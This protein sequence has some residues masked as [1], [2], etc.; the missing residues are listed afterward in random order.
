MAEDRIK[1][2]ATLLKRWD[3]W[4]DGIGHLVDSPRINGMYFA[5]GLLG[6]RRELRPAPFL[7]TVT[8]L[9]S[10][11]RWPASS[12]KKLTICAVA[13]NPSSGGTVTYDAVSTGGATSTSLTISHTCT[14]ANRYLTVGVST[15]GAAAPTGVT[16]DGSAMTKLVEDTTTAGAICSIWGIKNPSTGANN[17]I[18]SMG[19]SVDIRGGGISFTSVD[20]TT[21]TNDTDSISGTTG[22]FPDFWASS[23]ACLDNGRVVGVSATSDTAG[24]SK[25]VDE[26]ARWDANQG[27][28]RG[29]GTDRAKFTGYHPTYVVEEEETTN[30]R[31]YLYMYR[32][33]VDGSTTSLLPKLTKINIFDANFSF[34]QILGEFEFNTLSQPGQP[35]RYQGNWF[36][37]ASGSTISRKLTVGS[38]KT[39]ADTLTG[40]T[41]VANPTEDHLANLSH[42]L[43]GHRAT[44][45][46][47]ILKVDGTPTTEGDWGSYFSVGDKNERAAGLIG[48]QNLSFVMN[49]E[50]LFSFN[51][52]G[53]SGL[54]FE[55]FRTW[56]NVFENIPM[57]AWK[58]GILLPHPSGL[59][60]YTPGEQPIH[61][62]L[63]SKVGLRS[64][65]PSGPTEIHGGRYHGTKVVGEFI[66]AVYQPN[67]SS[68]TAYLTCAYSPSG[69]PTDLIWQILGSI[70]LQD[71]NYVMGVGV[72]LQSRPV[73][74]NYV[75]PVAWAGNGDDLNYVV[76]DSSAGPF[77][78]RADTHKVNTSANAYM[79]EIIFPE[80]VDLTEIVIYTQ[81]MISGD[82]WQLSAYHNDDTTDIHFGGPFIGNGK[83][84]RT[85]NLK[86]VTRFML[87]VN[88]AATS[89]ADR[90]PPTIKEIR[91]FGRPSDR[92][93]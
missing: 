25:S 90:V 26:T 43:I 34:A 79:S 39:S 3:S 12:T 24:I 62:G 54:V 8:M 75:T 1:P 19:G 7:N 20:Q 32:G 27:S 28:V 68:T 15:T 80:P 72:T 37:P 74:N 73:S 48:L 10:I 13:L 87:H 69:N 60:W 4:E 51:A 44:S 23:V 29:T 36:F 52:K 6:A 61:V 31:S 47:R 56:R 92:G 88:W 42:Q 30:T 86:N 17:I 9:E 77:R 5:S 82:E 14:G 85:L 66:Y 11:L 70:T 67:I 91:L 63:G 16:Y 41:S 84:S 53:R 93:A 71:A 81:D 89:T 83:D 18:I 2:K 22:S 57:S 65:P 35:A 33:N 21:P 64:I 58:G 38:G 46:A 40:P 45:G 55:D 50:G 49:Q 76:L 78:S 59:I